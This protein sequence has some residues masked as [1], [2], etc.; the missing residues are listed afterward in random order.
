MTLMINFLF[1]IIILTFLFYHSTFGQN[2]F[3]LDEQRSTVLQNIIASDIGVADLNN[4][5]INDIILY[6]YNKIG[7]QERLFLNTY[8][9]SSSGEID[10]IQMDILNG[11]FTY[12]PSNHS[13]RYIGGDGKLALGDYDKDGLIDVLAHGAEFMFMTKNLGGSLSTNNYLESDFIENLG[14]SAL[15]WG[16]VDLDG[17][18]DIFWMGLK[19]SRGTITN[20]LLLNQSDFNGNVAWE[21]DN[22]VVMPDLR[23]GAVAWD[24]IDLDGDLDLLTSGQQIT[25]ESGVTK[26]YLNDPIG[27]LGEDTN[28]EIEPLKGT[29]ICFSDL[30]NDA[31]SDLI[32]SGYSPIDSTLKTLIYINEP[33]GNFRLADQQINF[34][35][36]FG[37]IKAIDVNM[38][39]FKDIAIS[40]AVE[41]TI[42]Y[43]NFY[44][45]DT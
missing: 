15:R 10:T 17:D 1:K 24:D 14:E 21:F 34:G 43:D 40:G 33:T 6:G 31:D 8:S 32:I 28:Q 20:K 37:S 2:S 36:I 45:I 23:N 19:N 38:D 22:S 13:S 12:I 3:E 7:N 5:G 18:L 39:G 26:L 9:V 42:N 25:V 35:T 11:Y 44:I 30:D 16:D 27:R 4:D 29:S 41:H